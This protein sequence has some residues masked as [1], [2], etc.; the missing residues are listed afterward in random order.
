MLKE[1]KVCTS[2]RWQGAESVT[3]DAQV[4]KS[5]YT[6]NLVRWDNGR[7]V[8]NDMMSGLFIYASKPNHKHRTKQQW[9]RTSGFVMLLLVL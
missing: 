5:A 8:G 1:K 4:Q 7:V 3:Q 6:V 9:M 2:H